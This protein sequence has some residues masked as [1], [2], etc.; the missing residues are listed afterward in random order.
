MRGI[1]E[2]TNLRRPWE[3]IPYQHISEKLLRRFSTNLRSFIIL[4]LR[5]IR[6]GFSFD[7]SEKDLRSEKNLRRFSILPKYRGMRIPNYN[8]LDHFN[9][10]WI[11]FY[12]NKQTNLGAVKFRQLLTTASKA[13]GSKTIWA[14]V[15]PIL[16]QKLLI[17]SGGKPL[18]LNAV[19]VNN[20]G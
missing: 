1:W 5:R 8:T 4:S 9:N 19:N 18:L 16:A 17:A 13:E 14:P 2:K 11:L 6:E 3:R 10:N 7:I 12:Q 15:T 20:L